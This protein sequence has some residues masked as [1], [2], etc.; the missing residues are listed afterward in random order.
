MGVQGDKR[1]LRRNNSGYMDE[2]SYKVI[3]NGEP[4]PEES[5][6]FHDLLDEI[7]KV[8]EVAGFEIENRIVLKDT[9]TGRVWR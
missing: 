9:Q 1:S 3:K 6:R 2:T 8:A 7:R 5:E 4:T